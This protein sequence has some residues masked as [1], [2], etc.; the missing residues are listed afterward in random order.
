[1]QQPMSSSTALALPPDDGDRVTYSNPSDPPLR[2]LAIRAVER[3]TGQPRLQRLY[4]HYLATRRE[5]D[6]FWRSAIEHLR[7]TVRHDSHRLH[8]I[9]AE[10]PLIVVANHPFGVLDGI[11]IGYL[12]SRVRTDFKLMAHAALGRASVFRPY[13]IPVEFDGAST[14]L[15]E[16][17]AAKRAALAH[18]SEGGSLIMFPAG[19]VSTAPKVLGAATDAPWKLFAGKLVAASKATVVPVYFEGQ[20]GLLFHLVSQFSETLREALILR[21]VA[22]RIGADITARI[23]APLPFEALSGEPSRQ[24]LLDRLRDEVYGLRGAR[25]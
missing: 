5:D 16:N 13:L 6:L 25:P 3:L 15:R 10:G 2:R 21:E 4:D 18:L 11:A 9:P 8:A 12:M 20:N 7:L 19:R 23:G 22:K 24:A 14:A 1:M 17:V